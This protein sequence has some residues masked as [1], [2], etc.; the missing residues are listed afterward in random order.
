[1]EGDPSNRR[2]ILKLRG[3]GGRVISLYTVFPFCK[4]AGE[5]SIM[6]LA[7]E[8]EGRGA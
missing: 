1:M 7:S 4:M 3:W 8:F 5:Q 6:L 2:M